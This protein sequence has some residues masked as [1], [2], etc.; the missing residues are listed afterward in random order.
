L[1]SGPERPHL[2]LPR[3]GPPTPFRAKRGGG[4]RPEPPQRD[5][6]AH[7]EKLLGELN[8]AIGHA[9]G[10]A[11]DYL[12]LRLSTD[13]PAVLK[14]LGSS[15]AEL[16]T[17]R[18]GVGEGG[19]VV[20][21]VIVPAGRAEKWLGSKL[22]AYKTKETGKGRP[23]NE[24][25]SANIGSLAAGGPEEIFTGPGVFPTGAGPAW[26]QVWLSKAGAEKARGAARDLD[27]RVTDEA[28][29][30]PDS[31]VVLAY[32]TRDGLAAWMRST[33]AVHELALPE[34]PAVLELPAREQAA[35]ADE[36]AARLR[37]N[38]GA[39]AVC[40]L[41]AGLTRGHP[42]IAPAADV[43]DLYAYLP[44]W[45]LDDMGGPLPGHG[46]GMAGLALYGDLRPLLAGGLI[47]LTH[48]LE[49]VRILP[50]VGQNEP[51]LYG[52]ITRDSAAQ[53]AVARPGRRRVYCMAVTAEPAAGGLA[54]AWSGAVDQLCFGGGDGARLFILCAGNRR[55]A[56]D[57]PAGN[58][59]DPVE[60][61]AQAWNALTV[62]AFTEKDQIGAEPS[63]AGWRPVAPP[64]GL[65][66]TS[67]TS[68]P[69]RRRSKVAPIKPDAVMEGGNYATDGTLH[70]P[71]DSLRL[72]TTRPPG[73]GGALFSAFGDTSAA[74]ALAARLAAQVWERYPDYWPETVRGLVVHSASW[75]PAMAASAGGTMRS[76]EL[77]LRRCGYGVP[78]PQLALSS[79]AD[80]VTLV[81][82]DALQ[83]FSAEGTTR[84][85]VLYKPPWPA[86]YLQEL[87]G[88]TQVQLRVTLSYFIEPKPGRRG[89]FGKYQYPSH[90]LRF[91][92]KRSDE[93]EARF[94]SRVN[95]LADKVKDG[96]EGEPWRY[97]R[98]RDRGSVHSDFWEGDAAAL[99]KRDRL[100]V[101]PASGWWKEADEVT[102][103][104]RSARY[105]LIVSL[106]ALEPIAAN[107]DLY[108]EIENVIRT[109]T[110]VAVET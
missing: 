26:W 84:D 53:P 94:K 106:R 46:T 66:P 14:S 45:P 32:A 55:T 76:R 99:A 57:Y 64:G 7:A 28:L 21:T 62:G 110:A 6:A 2:P 51:R 63:Y 80:E 85:M 25:L 89:G 87:A 95:R 1:P 61:P 17:V 15:G 37:P 31:V 91:E 42:L 12:V 107:V 11:Q 78:D 39:T 27:I 102:V 65:S 82:Q 47:P 29:E 23:R 20:A 97:G 98:L 56:A 43:G 18:E 100:A 10:A 68:V 36:L 79:F 83:P 109:P 72:L 13:D 54:T 33:G 5:R 52:A 34:S 19:G 88:R 70:D 58:D 60:D 96:P 105:A 3:P 24:R 101:F 40:V 59:L 69:W 92:L 90:Q 38:L 93:S 103:R 50:P 41:D 16:A 67:R 108:A 4:A 73:A 75:T 8:A 30:F 77:V 71:P 104:T 48:R 74:T 44:A 86:A 9:A 49:S 81:G 22:K 35:L